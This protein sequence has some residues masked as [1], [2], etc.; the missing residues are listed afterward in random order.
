MR[1]LPAFEL[2]IL[3][4]HYVFISGEKHLWMLTL[5]NSLFILQDINIY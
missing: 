1:L 2:P 3:L 5:N 4:S